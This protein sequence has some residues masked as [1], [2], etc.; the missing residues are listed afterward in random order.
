MIKAEKEALAAA[1]II[2]DSLGKTIFD[3]KRGIDRPLEKGDI[4]I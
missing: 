4:V 2:K 3:S 1:R